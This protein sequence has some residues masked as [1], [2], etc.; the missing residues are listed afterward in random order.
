MKHFSNAEQLMDL[1]DERSLESANRNPDNLH[2]LFASGMVLLNRRQFE[3][4]L[5]HFERVCQLMPD[6]VS[7]RQW[8]AYVLAAM[9]RFD[10]AVEVADGVLARVEDI[11]F[12]LMRA[13]WLVQAG[14][15]ERARDECTLFEHCEK[16]NS[17]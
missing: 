16:Q 15:L 8:R 17:R 7:A 14:Q 10:E 1:I 4:A 3:S 11:D 13:E 6:S 12:R 5:E 9:E 2:G